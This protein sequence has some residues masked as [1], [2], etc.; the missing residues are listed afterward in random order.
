M[1]EEVR[2]RETCDFVL[3]TITPRMTGVYAIAEVVDDS[4]KRPERTVFCVLQRDGDLEFT[5]G[6]L[7][8]LSQVA[9]MVERNGG[10]FCYDLAEVARWLASECEQRRRERG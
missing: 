4:N 1:A 2:Q 5:P 8:S 10:C 7:R 6:Q 9:A 3:Y